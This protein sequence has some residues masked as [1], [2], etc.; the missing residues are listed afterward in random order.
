MF[1]TLLVKCPSERAMQKST[2]RVSPKVSLS[3]SSVLN[4]RR[5]KRLAQM[6]SRAAGFAGATGEVVQRRDLVSLLVSADSKVTNELP[7][8]RDEESVEKVADGAYSARVT[9]DSAHALTKLDSVHQVQT[10]KAK[11][12][13]LYTSPSPRD[14]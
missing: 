7:E 3:L 12:C 4:R 2:F 13:L 9:M 6:S 1:R 10:K 14:S 8:L 11:T 5:K